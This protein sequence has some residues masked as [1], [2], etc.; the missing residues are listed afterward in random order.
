MQDDAK[1][2]LA[3]KF[4][5]EGRGPESLYVSWANSGRVLRAVDFQYPDESKIHHLFFTGVQVVMF[6]PEEVIDYRSLNPTWSIV[7]PA[8]ILCLGK[9]AWLRS[10]SQQHLGNCSHFQIMFYDELL[11]VICENIEVRDGEYLP[12]S[13]RP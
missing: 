13:R 1:P 8:G 10:F 7:R 11:D 4:Y 9:S 6:T 5:A 3:E 12:E 2:F